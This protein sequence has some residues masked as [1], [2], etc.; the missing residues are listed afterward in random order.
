M[1]KKLV[2]FLN[3]AQKIILWWLFFLSW[4]E[5]FCLSEFLPYPKKWLNYKSVVI[6]WEGDEL[7]MMKR[8]IESVH[9]AR[10]YEKSL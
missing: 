6:E 9:S 7:I 8:E 4:F 10:R 3:D 1:L 2:R 5:A